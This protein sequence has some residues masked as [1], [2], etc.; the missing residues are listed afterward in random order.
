MD[1]GEECSLGFRKFLEGRGVGRS[2]ELSFLARR[3]RGDRRPRSRGGR[4]C[5]RKCNR[6]RWSGAFRLPGATSKVRRKK[7]RDRGSGRDWSIWI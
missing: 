2:G 4:G 1:E 5:T 7:F 3:R 6:R